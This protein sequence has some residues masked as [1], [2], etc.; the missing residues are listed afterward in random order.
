MSSFTN[1]APKQYGPERVKRVKFTLNVNFPV[2][3]DAV[4]GL[5]DVM[6]MKDLVRVLQKGEVHDIQLLDD[7]IV[8]NV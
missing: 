6:Y 1:Q 3:F 4:A 2:D 7:R 8:H 5:G